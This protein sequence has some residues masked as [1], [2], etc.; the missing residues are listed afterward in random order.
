MNTLTLYRIEHRK[1][2]RGP[3]CDCGP[4]M[5]MDAREMP[6]PSEDFREVADEIYEYISNHNVIFA[7]SSREAMLRWFKPADLEQLQANNFRVVK[8]RVPRERI[9]YVSEH[10]A[11]VPMTIT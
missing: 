10:Q 9:K 8:L 7:F 11:I 2:R 3:F 6:A 1:T 5:F 4:A